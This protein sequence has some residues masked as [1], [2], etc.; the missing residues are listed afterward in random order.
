MTRS[1]LA[2]AAVLAGVGAA[3]TVH[4]QAPPGAG[5]Q[6]AVLV[7][8]RTIQGPPPP[9]AP[10]VIRRDTAG[11]ATVRAVEL[12]QPLQVDGRLDETVYA[13]VAPFGGFIQQLPDEGEP[14]SERTEAWVFYRRRARLRRRQ[15][16]GVGARGAVDRQYPAPR[17]HPDPRQ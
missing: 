15:A 14:A 8:G 4:A 2:L 16:V 9:V 5:P 17:F 12:A 11:R 6:P 7:G 1:G 3:E 10:E 13:E